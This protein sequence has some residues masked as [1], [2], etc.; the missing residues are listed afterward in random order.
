MSVS[1]ETLEGLA[2]RYGLPAGA[3]ERFERLLH[4]LAAEPDPPTTVRSPDEAVA[5]H[6]ADSLSGLE[7]EEL[8]RAGAIADLGSG[9]GFPGL[10]LAVALPGSRL[11]L[12]EASG[13][14][15]E[16][17][18]RLAAA[19]QAGNSRVVRARV[20]EW[21][22]AEGREAYDV[23]TAR[24]LDS[25]AVLVEYAAP[26]LREG[27]ALVAWKGSREGSEE[28]AGGAAATEVGL[29]PREV[30][31]VEPFEGARAR[32]LHVY[33]KVGPTPDRF[34]RRPGMARKRPL[35]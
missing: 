12:I 13:R 28:E 15:C 23:V 24:A 1:R 21:G 2:S 27:G 26:L 33:S 6:L 34:P 30:Q 4:A 11:D 29:E 5:A 16:V 17:I 19:A 3:A 20:E 10:V 18:E 31:R 7:V 22:A 9:A 32:H 8:G 25:L 35:G 14:K